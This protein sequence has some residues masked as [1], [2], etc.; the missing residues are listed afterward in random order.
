MGEPGRA[1]EPDRAEGAHRT[2]G[3]RGDAA[4]DPGGHV[5][6]VQHDGSGRRSVEAVDAAELR[7][8]APDRWLNVPNALTAVRIILVPFILVLVVLGTDVARWW[9]F[10][11]FTF[12]AVTDQID[13]W[14]ARR[15][16]GVTRWGQIADPIADKL[17]VIGTLA[18]LAWMDALPWW[19]VIVIIVREV[20]VT[21]LR[22]DLHRKHD[23]VMPASRWGKAKTISQ[24]WA[25]GLFL[26]PGVP[27]WL[28]YGLLYVAVAAT[29]VSGI[30]YAFRAGRLIREVRTVEP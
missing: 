18:T 6:V 25:V 30:D 15:W 20:A 11:L 26:V 16:Y 13:G 22:I 1:D 19:A 2:E 4:S 14:V 5:N 8:E 9:A 17:L 24:L 21:L 27:S 3:G 23:L 7:S 28:A 29:V 12:A 10:G